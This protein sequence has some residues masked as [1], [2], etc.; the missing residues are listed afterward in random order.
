M[1]SFELCNRFTFLKLADIGKI[2]RLFRGNSEINTYAFVLARAFAYLGLLL[3]QEDV[4]VAIK[5]ME[6][7]RYVDTAAGRLGW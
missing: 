3:T 7:R 2:L 5:K 6:Y 1:K 4:E